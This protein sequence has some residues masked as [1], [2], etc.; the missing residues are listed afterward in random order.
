MLSSM[1]LGIVSLVDGDQS[2]PIT[3]LKV[4]DIKYIKLNDT[5]DVYRGNTKIGTVTVTAKDSD[6]DTLTINSFGTDLKSSDELWISGT[7]SG[8]RIFRWADNPESGID[9][10]QYDTFKIAGGQNDSITMMANIGD[11]MVISNKMNLAIWDDSSLKNL[12]LGIGCTSKRGYVKTPYGLFFLAY[13]GIYKMTGGIP[14]LISFKVEPYITGA[15]KVGLEAGAMGKKGSSIFCYIGDVTLYNPDGSTKKSLTDVVLEYNIRIASW[16]VHTGIKATEF[17]TYIATNDADILTFA[18]EESGY[19]IMELF[20][21][22]TTLDDHVTSDAEIPFRIDTGNIY[23]AKRF[24]NFAYP[25]QLITEVERGSAMTCFISLDDGDW[26]ELG[27][28]L[29]KGINVIKIESKDKSIA[30]PPRC[31]KLNISFRDNSSQLCKISRF[32][33][34]YDPTAEEDSETVKLY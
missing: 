4:T 27:G 20:N 21:N 11:V 14:E 23:L 33:I 2:N 32:A 24:E 28:H 22:N 8:D 15:T 5:L 9:I 18:S 17:S 25:V 29:G 3:S 16:Y 34:I 26:Y 10:K 30:N 7:Y 12:D 6:T 19:Q 13:N 1:P 31:R